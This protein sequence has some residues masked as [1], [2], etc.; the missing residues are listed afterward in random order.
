MF[1][2]TVTRSGPAFTCP[3]TLSSP[4]EVLLALT[5]AVPDTNWS[6]KGREAAAVRIFL[7]GAYHQDVVLFAGAEPFTYRRGLGEVPAGTHH[8]EMAFSEPVA[9]PNSQRAELLDLEVMPLALDEELALVYRYAPLLHG[10]RLKHPYENGQ[11]DTP[12]VAFH[13]RWPTEKGL[14][15]EYQ[16]IWSH[17][18]AGTSAS[19]LLARWGHV[20]DIEWIFRVTV[21]PDGALLEQEYQGPEHV[22]TPFRGRFEL[23]KHPVLQTATINNNVTD[24]ITSAHRFL[25]LPEAAWPAGRA[26][27]AVMAAHPWTYR[28]SALEVARQVGFQRPGDPSQPAVSDLRNYLWLELDRSTLSGSAGLLGLEAQV[29]L[30][31]SHWY[32][33]SFGKPLLAKREDGPYSTA[34]KLPDGT[35][36][37]EITAIAAA[38]APPVVG[39]KLL[40]RGPLSAFMLDEQYLPSRSLAVTCRE[41]ILS[42]GSSQATLWQQGI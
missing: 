26:R 2:S 23:G 40:V 29:Q 12:L 35:R 24:R 34:V 15:I 33:S 27:E 14:R 9:S 31:F 41:V 28:I 13:R 5:A 16:M 1:P 42:R 20:S 32:R 11:T 6:A 17:E 19:A 37:E 25:L 3:F 4:G 36:P 7:D 8:L 22:T 10:R 30:R 38:L 39:G 18:D 21:G